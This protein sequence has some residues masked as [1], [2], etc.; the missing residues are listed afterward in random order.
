MGIWKLSFCRRVF[1]PPGCLPLWHIVPIHW[2]GKLPF[3]AGLPL[4]LQ[5][6]VQPVCFRPVRHSTFPDIRACMLLYSFAGALQSD[7]DVLFL[8][9]NIIFRLCIHDSSALGPFWTL[10][11]PPQWSNFPVLHMSK[12]AFWCK[13]CALKHVMLFMGQATAEVCLWIWSKWIS[14]TFPAWA[15][16]ALEP[17]PVEGDFWRVNSCRGSE[18]KTICPWPAGWQLTLIEHV[19]LVVSSTFF[20]PSNPMIMIVMVITKMMNTMKMMRMMKM[21]PIC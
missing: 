18:A 4:L 16:A 6:N 5:L 7:V 19:K 1:H 13:T 8:R 12:S 20:V 9:I 11:D 15:L 10:L 3:E 21:K 14:R 17:K 2:G